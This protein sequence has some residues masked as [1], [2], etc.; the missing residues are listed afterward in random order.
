M[1]A[2]RFHGFDGLMA[3]AAAAATIASP[4]MAHASTFGRRDPGNSSI[5]SSNSSNT[6]H[7]APPS[8]PSTPRFEYRPAP[9]YNPAPAYRPAPSYSP[10]PVYRPA[11]SYNPAP[12]YRPAPSYNPAPVYR[13]APAGGASQSYQPASAFPY[14]PQPSSRFGRRTLPGAGTVEINPAVPGGRRAWNGSAGGSGYR[15]PVTQI[16]G[17]VINLPETHQYSSPHLFGGLLGH[18]GHHYDSSQY[19]V[20]GYYDG[21]HY[22]GAGGHITLPPSS[23]P[24][25]SISQPN[26][27][28]RYHEEHETVIVDNSPY[29][30]PGYYGG[31]YPP[32]FPCYPNTGPQVVY[33]PD[34]S[35]QVVY[36]PQE[37]QVIY[38]PQQPQVLYIPDT[39]PTATVDPY[40]PATVSA[41]DPAQAPVVVIQDGASADSSS[42][43]G[44]VL[45]VPGGNPPLDDG[46]A[47]SN[48]PDGA[49]KAIVDIQEA[50][51]L[52]DSTLIQRHLDAAHPVR[53]YL[54]GKLDFTPSTSEYLDM[55][56]KALKSLSTQT[57][58]LN[59]RSL[60]ADG[61]VKAWGTQ[62]FTDPDNH[63]QAN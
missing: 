37:P 54:A 23:G 15:D 35:P 61:R 62:V 45:D 48:I 41:P 32:Y 36:V 50:W 60:L 33:V 28:R 22:Q 7:P 16:S 10:A 6:Y 42:S 63:R 13:P 12:A 57:F 52:S 51:L 43:S 47:V 34:P 44:D 46:R 59:H 19:P 29:Y 1:S 27:Y 24:N 38:V 14:E 3:A 18:T 56:S 58:V 4:M 17:G 30:A 9:S 25:I 26:Q 49:R 39:T 40:G 5:S 31:Y 53:M 2:Q 21:S 8:Q 20:G 55:T 11:P